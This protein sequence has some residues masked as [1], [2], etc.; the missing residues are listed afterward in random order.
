MIQFTLQNEGVPFPHYWEHCVGSCHAYTALREDYRKQLKRAHDE[1]GFR[2]VRF[3]GLFNDQMS[4]L[5]MKKDH[6]GNELGLAYNFVNIDNI[7]DWLLDNGMK[8]FI[9]LGFMP[10]AIAS[11]DRTVFHYQ[12]NITP[13]KDYKAWEELIDKLTTH[14][15]ERYGIDEV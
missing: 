3:H 4:V 7:F 10:T 9:E 14:L 2:Y 13:P 12:G 6:V 11:G 5:V 8:P 15:V 1:L